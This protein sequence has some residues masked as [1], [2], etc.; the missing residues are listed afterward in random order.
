VTKA[1]KSAMGQLDILTL[2]TQAKEAAVAETPKPKPASEWQS[3][4]GTKWQ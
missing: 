2:A 3:V 1:V 4:Q